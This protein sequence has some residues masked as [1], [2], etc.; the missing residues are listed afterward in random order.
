MNF[1][2]IESGH[3][4]SFVKSAVMLGGQRGMNSFAMC[5]SP[6]VGRMTAATALDTIRPKYGRPHPFEAGSGAREECGN[7]LYLVDVEEAKVPRS[8]FGGSKSKGH[9]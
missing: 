9:I 3:I 2:T 7:E 4:S 6:R 5:R 8:N 1:A